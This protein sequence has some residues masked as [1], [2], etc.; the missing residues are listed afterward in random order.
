MKTKIK[1]F[2]ARENL[3][4]EKLSKKVGVSRQT[5]LFIEKGKYCPSLILAIKI[6]NVFNCK[7][8]EL[9]LFNKEEIQNGEI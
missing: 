8:E 7:V 9:F 2:R 4:Q 5:I 3:T 1:E 6:C